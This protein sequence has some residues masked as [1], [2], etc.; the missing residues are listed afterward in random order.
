MKIFSSLFIVT[1]CITSTFCLA[2]DFK[3][4]VHKLECED[5]TL[6]TDAEL[7]YSILAAGI[8]E[9]DRLTFNELMQ[10][11]RQTRDSMISQNQLNDIPL[12]DIV[13]L[14]EFKAGGMDAKLINELMK[15]SLHTLFYSVD[16]ADIGKQIS[17]FQRDRGFEV[18]GE[19]TWE[20]YNTLNTIANIAKPN[21]FFFDG[22]AEVYQIDANSIF[23]KGTWDIIGDT[24]GF[25][26]SSSLIYCDKRSEVC[27]EEYERAITH[28]TVLGIKVPRSIYAFDDG[29]NEYDIIYWDAQE[30]IAK[31]RTANDNCRSVTLNINTRTSDVQQV[32]TQNESDCPSNIPRL[33]SARVSKLVNA[34]DFQFA[35][36]TELENNVRCLSAKSHIKRI[37]A[38][39]EKITGKP[40]KL[41]IDVGE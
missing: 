29:E 17:A 36:W 23:V 25:P 19:L 35:Y 21:K 1:A 2:S 30:I 28:E 12:K 9:K 14:P 20:Q 39:S 8:L 7:E 15:V 40:G 3:D 34:W 5:L 16:E 10:L 24:E 4:C 26:V 37:N 38:M 18:T 22:S 33:E 31:Q 41:C 32:V 6:L 13:R 11:T 27:T